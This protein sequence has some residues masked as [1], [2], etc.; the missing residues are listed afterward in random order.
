MHL[1]IDG[2]LSSFRTS[3]ATTWHDNHVKAMMSDTTL[4]MF[5]LPRRSDSG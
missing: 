1:P 4:D 3:A 2:V 5:M